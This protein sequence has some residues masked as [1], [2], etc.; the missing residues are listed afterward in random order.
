MATLLN[1]R[2]ITITEQGAFTLTL[3]LIDVDPAA[4][5][6]EPLHLTFST[7]LIL[8]ADNLSA[9]V[10]ALIR[11]YNSG[12]PDREGFVKALKDRAHDSSSGSSNPLHHPSIA[13]RGGMLIANIITGK[14][15]PSTA[16]TESGQAAFAFTLTDNTPAVS[17]ATTKASSEVLFWPGSP[18]SCGAF[19]LTPLPDCITVTT[20][21]GSTLCTFTTQIPK[22]PFEFW[23][24]IDAPS[25]LALL[26]AAEDLFPGKIPKALA[27]AT[28]S[29]S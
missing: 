22:Q 19:C 5:C 18:K 11:H 12:D 16:A 2:K 6:F 10:T 4:Q 29:D 20:N 28:A 7:P 17:R 23:K 21:V 3:T 8:S 25:T 15:L 13:V 9:V 26:P 27:L 14:S 24:L 1:T